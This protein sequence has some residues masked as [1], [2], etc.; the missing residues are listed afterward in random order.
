M[1][2]A[3][4][5]NLPLLKTTD[6]VKAREVTKQAAQTIRP[7][8]TEQTTRH[9]AKSMCKAWWDESINSE[10]VP[11]MNADLGQQRTEM[12]RAMWP[13][14]KIYVTLCWPFFYVAARKQMISMLHHES[15]VSA[16]MKERIHAAVLEDM[17]EKGNYG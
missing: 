7:L 9:L 13:D 8:R 12:F 5:T 2:L 11:G 15:G 14:R 4:P 17:G 3:P 10:K 1:H 16:V 6:I